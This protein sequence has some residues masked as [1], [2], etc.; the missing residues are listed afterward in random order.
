M[1]EGQGNCFPIAIVQQCRRPDVIVNLSSKIQQ[2]IKQDKAHSLLRTEVVKF[3]T[4]SQNLKIGSFKEEYEQNVADAVG[5]TW[6]QYWL[7]MV[8][9]RTEVDHMFVQGTAWFLEVDI[10][11]VD[12]SCTMVNPYIHISGNIENENQS[13]KELIYL[14]SKSDIHYQSLL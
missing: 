2:I 7:K 4:T 1:T 3:M 6:E 11:I 9:D 5:E 13:C 8:T 14:G 10:L 12:T